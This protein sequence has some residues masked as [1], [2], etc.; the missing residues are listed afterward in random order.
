[1]RE[2]LSL[3]VKWKIG[4]KRKPS[5]QKKPTK[6]FKGEKGGSITIMHPSRI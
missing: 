4:A 3:W 1:M 6:T 2:V 5:V